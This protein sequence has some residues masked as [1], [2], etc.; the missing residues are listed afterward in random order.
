M[1]DPAWVALSLC[2]HL[3]GKTFR[4][5]LAHFDNDLQAILKAEAKQLQQV[6]GIGPKIARSIREIDLSRTEKDIQRWQ[7]AG[8]TLLTW[9]DASYPNAL[10][11]VDD[12]PPTVFLRG[13]KTAL[14][15]KP[16][17]AVVGTRSPTP[18][19]KDTAQRFGMA[20]AETGYAIVSGLALGIDTAAHMGALAVPDGVTYAV[21]GSGVLKIYPPANESLAKAIMGRGAL[22]C[23]VSP[24]ATVNAAGLVARNRMITGLCKG[25]IVVETEIDGGAM[26][27]VRFAKN[28]GIAIYVVENRASGN[29]EL[30]N[31]EDACAIT[32]NLE[33]L[34]DH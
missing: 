1:I 19:A 33:G 31:H 7:Q 2:K 9:Q 30:L 22:L 5:L 18:L 10:K 4:T 8:I 29:R 15:E 23:E 34:S 25:L 26:H 21:L 17:Y 11:Q 28:Q 3:G 12:A 6:R 20:L 32:P 14:A 13:M 24:D 16:A 27:A